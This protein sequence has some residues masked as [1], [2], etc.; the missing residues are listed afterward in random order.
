MFPSKRPRTFHLHAQV[1]LLNG[2]KIRRQKFKW[3][4]PKNLDCFNLKPSSNYFLPCRVPYSITN[5][6]ICWRSNSQKIYLK[7]KYFLCCCLYVVSHL[8]EYRVIQ[9]HH[10]SDRRIHHPLFEKNFLGIR[11]SI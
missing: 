11:S 9:L 1:E 8:V 4:F 7:R 3:N 5:S 6:L 2:I 10:Q